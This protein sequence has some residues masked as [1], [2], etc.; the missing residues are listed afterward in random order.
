MSAKLNTYYARCL[1]A[2]CIFAFTGLT[3]MAQVE[4]DTVKRKPTLPTGRPG[5]E[6]PVYTPKPQPQPQPKVQQQPPVVQEEPEEAEK[7]KQEFIDKLYFGGSFGLQFGSYTNI[8]LLPIIGYKV[9]DK[10]SVGT[11][12]VYH[13]ISD[14]GISLNNFGG[15]G[16]T[17]M[18]VFDIMDGA[19]LA[20]AEVEVLSREY[21]M[22]DNSNRPLYKLRKTM[23]L[24]MIGIGY[25]QR[26]GEKAS[27]DL[28]LLYNAN[29]DIVNPYSNP[30]IRAGI[31]IP[32]RK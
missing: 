14:G 16:F 32:F 22:L 13:F 10:F 26:I 31:N 20:H 27:L 23:T 18:E 5:T 1:L 9:T 29:D 8:T 21:L 15:R 25:R 3:A 30:V 12:V 2:L 11:G 24:P 7:E 19:L 28:L 17:Q 4:P 6:Q